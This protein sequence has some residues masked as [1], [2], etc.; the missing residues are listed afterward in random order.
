MKKRVGR[1]IPMS[2]NMPQLIFQRAES[3][4]LSGGQS[5]SSLGEL[6]GGGGGIPDFPP[7]V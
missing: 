2:I 5:I 6:L 4:P 1:Q 7:S 3:A